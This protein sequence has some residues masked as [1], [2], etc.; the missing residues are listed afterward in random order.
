[1]TNFVPKDIQDNVNH[2][3]HYNNKRCG[4]CK[5]NLPVSCFA[6]NRAK[7]DGL[8]ERCREC[9]AKH[10]KD[11][12]YVE[13]SRDNRL[14]NKYGISL[15]DYEAMFTSQSGMCKIC[16]SDEEDLVVDHCHDTGIV[17]GL[18]CNRC[19]WGLGNFKDNVDLL[20]AAE[21]YLLNG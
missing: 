18:L 14:K 1:M 19:N 9:R 4:R 11:T 10:Y 5:R 12:G 15:E 17:R 7:K 2:P 16:R 13:T 6:K 8:Q 20:R 21:D 3:V